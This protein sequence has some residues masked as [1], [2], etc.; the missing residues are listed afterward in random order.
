MD[1]REPRDPVEVEDLNEGTMRSI[2]R[3]ILM[4]HR[5]KKAAKPSEDETEKP[6]KPSKHHGY[7]YM[8]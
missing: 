5:P 7:G 3:S 6:R 1:D 8:G 2:V 4:R